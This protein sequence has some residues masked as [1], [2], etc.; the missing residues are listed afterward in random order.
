MHGLLLWH[1]N[2]SSALEVGD[3]A[4]TPVEFGDNVRCIQQQSQS[5]VDLLIVE[6]IHAVSGIAA[7]TCMMH[8]IY[9]HAQVRVNFATC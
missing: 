6:L 8:G 3:H 1:S 7:S 9:M 2:P 4:S 5:P